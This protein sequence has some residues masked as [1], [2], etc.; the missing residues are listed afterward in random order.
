MD[1]KA[2]AAEYY[3]LDPE[4][5]GDVPFYLARIP[6]PKGEILEL[7]CGTGRVLVPLAASCGY[8]HGIEQ[9]DAMLRICGQKLA[10][11]SVPAERANVQLGD[12]TDFDLEA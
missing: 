10:N 8:I 2:R 12:V 4:S 7:G 5:L 1:T 11:N 9:S 3:D 6:S